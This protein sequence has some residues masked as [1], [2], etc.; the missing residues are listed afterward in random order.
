MSWFVSAGQP[1]L[2]CVT[3]R[4]V[5]VEQKNDQIWFVVFGLI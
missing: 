1:D 5:K 3:Y 2:K 4:E